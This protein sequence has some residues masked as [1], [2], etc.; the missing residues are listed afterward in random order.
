M[1]YVVVVEPPN[2]G[3]VSS[4]CELKSVWLVGKGVSDAPKCSPASLLGT[5]TSTRQRPGRDGTGMIVVKKKPL[6]FLPK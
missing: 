1:S 5:S 6:L 2:S 4:N 3:F